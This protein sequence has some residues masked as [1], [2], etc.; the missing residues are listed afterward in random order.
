MATLHGVFASFF[1]SLPCATEQ[2]LSHTYMPNR[3][4][5]QS[6]TTRTLT[7]I[8]EGSTRNVITQ[9]ASNSSTH[10]A[11]RL[12]SCVLNLAACYSRNRHSVLGPRWPNNIP[13]RAL[14]HRRARPS[15]HCT[16]Q[17]AGSAPTAPSVVN[18]CPTLPCLSRGLTFPSSAVSWAVPPAH[19]HHA[20]H[21]Q[22]LA[23]S[24]LHRHLLTPPGTARCT[25]SS[26]SGKLSSKSAACPVA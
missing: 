2:S 19:A 4:N 15:R 12:L 13:L 7:E 18:W 6:I 5:I 23:I 17:G 11:R 26:A 3:S 20:N 9:Q 21:W 25:D 1:I 22:Q 14:A 24:T 16:Q 10:L 8:P